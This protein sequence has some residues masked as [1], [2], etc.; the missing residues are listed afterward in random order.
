MQKMLSS[1]SENCQLVLD[2]ENGRTLLERSDNRWRVT[3]RITIFETEVLK[4]RQALSVLLNEDLGLLFD[5]LAGCVVRV[6]QDIG[7]RLKNF[8]RS[9]DRVVE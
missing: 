1:T 6:Y 3:Q 9:M 5:S 7:T 8:F 2:Q 4:H